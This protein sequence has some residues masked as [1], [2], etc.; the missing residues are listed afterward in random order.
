MENTRARVASLE[1][2]LRD[3]DRMLVRDATDIIAEWLRRQLAW[4]DVHARLDWPT[5]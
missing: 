3:T 2:R 4:Y 1:T 5:C